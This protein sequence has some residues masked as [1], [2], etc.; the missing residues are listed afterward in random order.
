MPM[1][2]AHQGGQIAPL[3]PDL[4]ALKQLTQGSGKGSQQRGAVS[5]DRLQWWMMSNGDH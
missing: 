3:R 5:Q 1:Q 2:A 4:N